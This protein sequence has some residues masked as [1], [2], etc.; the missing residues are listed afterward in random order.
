MPVSSAVFHKTC[1]QDPSPVLLL[2]SRHIG[3]PVPWCLS[4]EGPRTEHSTQGAASP[5]KSN[6]FSL[7]NST[8]SNAEYRHFRYYLPLKHWMQVYGLKE[9]HPGSH[10]SMLLQ[11]FTFKP[12]IQIISYTRT[13]TVIRATFNWQFIWNNLSQ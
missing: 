3:A 8:S 12:I 9:E 4:C 7:S 2:F 10:S 13:A 6:E 5:E 11:Q 1:A